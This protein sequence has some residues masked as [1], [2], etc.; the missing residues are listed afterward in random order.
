MRRL[1]WS[2][3]AVVSAAVGTAAFM[4]FPHRVG[5]SVDEAAATLP[6]DNELPDVDL[7][8][9][10]GIRIAATPEKVWAVVSAAFHADS[11]DDVVESIEN[12]ALVTRVA[13]P[14]LGEDDRSGIATIAIRPLGDGEVLLHVRERHQST[15][16][17]S[18]WKMRVI[19]AAETMSVLGM[20][21]DIKEAAQ[22]I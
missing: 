16:E 21:G 19:L 12:E 8:I 15:P 2:S 1:L 11:A 20:L 14:G 18:L 6:G 4:G 22:S 3:V 5:L 10:R 13:G 17:V 7:V 9:D